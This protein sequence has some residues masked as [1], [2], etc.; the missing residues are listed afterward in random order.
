MSCIYD[1]SHPPMFVFIHE[2]TIHTIHSAPC[3]QQQ[4]NTRGF[5][6]RSINKQQHLWVS[7]IGSIHHTL[8]CN[9]GL[10]SM[11]VLVPHMRAQQSCLPTSHGHP[12]VFTPLCVYGLMWQGLI[13]TGEHVM[14]W[15]VSLLCM[16]SSS[17]HHLHQQ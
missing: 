13:N 9:T 7:P 2:H 5:P 16:Y 8:T 14:N 4:H 3:Q 1:A 11:W 10:T 17:Q 12:C 15:H 6:P